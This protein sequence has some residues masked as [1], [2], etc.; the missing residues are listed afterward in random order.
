[1]PE[2]ADNTK[3]IPCPKCKYVDTAKEICPACHGLGELNLKKITKPS[4]R[5]K[6]DI[7]KLLGNKL[8][9]KGLKAN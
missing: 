4:Y 9:F 2:P 7:T 8:K 1:M 5:A 6:P 3:R